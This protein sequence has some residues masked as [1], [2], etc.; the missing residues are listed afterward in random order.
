MKDDENIEIDTDSIFFGDMDDDFEE[1]FERDE[2]EFLPEED[3]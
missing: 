2:D 3:N 1:E